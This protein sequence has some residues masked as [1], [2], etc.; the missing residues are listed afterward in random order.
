MTNHFDVCMFTGTSR[1]R[2][3]N[4]LLAVLSGRHLRL[5]DVTYL[6]TTQLRVSSPH[7]IRV[8]MDGE[9]AGLL[10]MEFQIVPDALTLLV[11]PRFA[12]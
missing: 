12:R 5:A 3:L 7:Q 8:Q 11:P 1:L 4:Y 2:Y 9:L 10:P 6:H